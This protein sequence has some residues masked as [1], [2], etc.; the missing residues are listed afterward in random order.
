M[1]NNKGQFKKGE[2]RPG[3]GCPPKGERVAAVRMLMEPD[4]R[5]AIDA[6]WKAKLD[7]YRDA[8]NASRQKLG[9][10]SDSG[11]KSASW[12][13][14]SSCLRSNN[15]R[16]TTCLCGRNDTRTI[17]PGVLGGTEGSTT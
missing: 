4:V 6:H 3:A 10:C 15:V 5:A 13:S 16:H 9:S 11:I 2:K 12:L 17:T 8:D 1:A 7:E 14:G